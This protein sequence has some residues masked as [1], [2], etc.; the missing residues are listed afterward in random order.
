MD[1]YIKN[2]I[3]YK[4]LMSELVVRDIKI[5]YRRSFLGIL[6]SL[7]NPLLMMIVM[8]I[9][10][11][12]LFKSKIKNYAVYLLTGQIIFAFLSEAT[13]V[14]MQSIIGNS[15]LIKKVYIPKY[16]FPVAKT[17]SSFVN[18][19]FSLVAIVIM[20]IVTKTKISWVI[21]L[22]PIP[23]IYVLLFSM[24]VGLILAAYAVFFRDIVHL[25]GVMLMVWNYMTPIIYPIDII[26][27]KYQ[28]FIKLNPLYYLIEEFRDIVLYAKL[29][30]AGLNFG[31]ICI[32]VGTLALGMYL[33]YRKQDQFILYI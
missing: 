4:D 30:S 7:L 17:L 15:A 10:F 33:F 6:W 26:P 18:L 1:R 20:L 5:K 24:G 19:L 2:F 8:T 9:V 29:P 23:L 27:H 14:S 25:Y 21:L 12:F 11:S 32:G 3:K 13:S 16:I 28:I 31:C 22:F